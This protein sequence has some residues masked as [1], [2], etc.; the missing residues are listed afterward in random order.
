MAGVGQFGEEAGEEVDG[1]RDRNETDPDDEAVADGDVFDQSSIALGAPAEGLE[2]GADS[3]NEVAA[4]QGHRDDV[5]EDHEEIL[6]SKHD[7]GVGVIGAESGQISI[8]PHGEVEDVEN[9][10]SEDGFGDLLTTATAQDD[11]RQHNTTATTET[12]QG[13]YNRQ[14]QWR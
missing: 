5:E 7:H 12:N 3:M 10:E 9:D 14:W 4:E 13:K 1:G 11:N 2:D 8:R 6:E